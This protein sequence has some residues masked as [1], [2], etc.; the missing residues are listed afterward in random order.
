MTNRWWTYQSERFP[1]LAHGPLILAF[2]FCAVSYSRLLRNDD[3]FPS[4]K[5]IIVAFASC[6]IFFLQLRIADEFKDFDEDSQFRPYRPVPRGLVNLRELAAVF[7]IGAVIQ[8]GLAFLLNIKM[9]MMLLGVWIYLA[10]MSKEFFVR[11]WIT[12][13]HITYM[14]THML[15]M[16]LVDFYAT[17]CDWLPLDQAPPAG[18]YWFVIVSFFNGIVIEIGRKVRHPDDEEDGVNTYSALWGVKRAVTVWVVMLWLTAAIAFMTAMQLPGNRWH[19]FGG[20]VFT[21][22]ATVASMLAIKFIVKPM[23]GGGKTIEA[24]AGVWTLVMYLSLGA[25]PMIWQSMNP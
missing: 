15:I 12:K 8:L 7:V 5:A 22:V 10:L 17:A 24:M 3:G 9:A 14:W 2:S 4:W 13:R 20:I 11:E 23:P 25:V 21:T 18:L 16:P 19:L 1:I 6:L